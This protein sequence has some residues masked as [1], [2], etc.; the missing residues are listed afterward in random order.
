[1]GYDGQLYI[2][3]KAQVLP[4]RVWSR[5]VREPVK[6]MACTRFAVLFGQATVS[7]RAVMKASITVGMI[8]GFISLIMDIS[9][10]GL[11]VVLCL[12]RRM[13]RTYL[14]VAELPLNTNW[15]PGPAL[16]NW[17]SRLGVNNKTSKDAAMVLV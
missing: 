15:L 12:L 2:L 5:R 7:V 3:A 8:S 17:P 16:I 4:A 1:M 10:V 11:Q 6:S 14:R 13:S 9:Y